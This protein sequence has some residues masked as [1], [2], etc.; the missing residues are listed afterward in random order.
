MIITPGYHQQT[1]FLQNSIFLPGCY[2][3]L[4]LESGAIP[5]TNIHSVKFWGDDPF[6]YT[7]R[8]NSLYPHCYGTN[9]D[10]KFFVHFE[11]LHWISAIVLQ[12]FNKDGVTGRVAKFSMKTR[13][14]ALESGITTY[15]NQFTV[16]MKPCL[17]YDST[18]S[19]P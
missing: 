14:H 10:S 19:T 1:N 11:E 12:G 9:F 16:R 18:P 3:G 17:H 15:D 6:A 13:L 2:H 7:G 5:D 8:L 4:G